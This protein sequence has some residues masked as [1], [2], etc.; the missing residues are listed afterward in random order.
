M[1]RL[2]LIL[3]VTALLT[4]GT[5]K[6]AEVPLPTQPAISPDGQTIVFAWAGDLWT[7]P[8]QG[9]DARRLTTHPADDR[10]P[11]FSPDGASIAFTSSRS[12]PSGLF[13]M[14]P[15]GTDVQ[16]RLVVDRASLLSGF[17]DDGRSTSPD[18]SSPTSTETRGRTR[19]R[20]RR[21]SSNDCTTPSAASPT[22]E[23]G[24]DRFLFVRG[25]SSG[26]P[27]AQPQAGL[28]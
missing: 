13:T 26:S 25:D 12:G 4:P 3:L 6:A 10:L 23:I 11:R 20:P 21:A 8:A 1:S 7:V 17:G 19:S 22:K 24:G 27:A 15:Q 9:G 18:S 14:S 28:P 5:A 16:E 2:A